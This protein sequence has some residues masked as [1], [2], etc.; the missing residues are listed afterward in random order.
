MVIKRLGAQRFA[1]I[2]TDVPALPIDADLVGAIFDATDAIRKWV[3]NG[4]AWI[5]FT[6]SGGAPIITAPDGTT[7]ELNM[8]NDGRMTIV[9]L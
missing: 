6:G 1:G 3:F 4:T 8:T 9:P 7:G 5:E 2:V